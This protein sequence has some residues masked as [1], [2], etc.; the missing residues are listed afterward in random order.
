MSIMLDWTQSH[1]IGHATDGLMAAAHYDGMIYLAYKNK[2]NNH[3]HVTRFH[4]RGPSSDPTTF[5]SSPSL[6][7]SDG[8]SAA[9]VAGS[10]TLAANRQDGKLY[11]V[12]VDRNQQMMSSTFDASRAT[13]NT[14][15]TPSEVGEATSGAV[16]LAEYDGLLYLVYKQVSDDSIYA[17]IWDGTS[18][19][20]ATD[21]GA[22][23]NGGSISLSVLGEGKQHGG[24]AMDGLHQ[25]R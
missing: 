14:W 16:A 6:E 7:V 17:R 22:H 13:R 23:S 1:P 2:S 25:R 20:E 15:S 24:Y 21:T 11:V 8:S 10:I 4:D 19:S 18:W 12:Y 9:E 5:W 3:I